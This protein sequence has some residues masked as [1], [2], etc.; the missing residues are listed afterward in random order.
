MLLSAL[1]SIQRDVAEVI[2]LP[3]PE[4]YVTIRVDTH[5]KTLRVEDVMGPWDVSAKLRKVFGFLQKH[6][7]VGNGSYFAGSAAAFLFFIIT[8]AANIWVT[9]NGIKGGIE[10]LCNWAMPTLFVLGVILAIRV[11]TLDAPPGAP[12]DQNAINGLGFLW[13]PDFSTLSDPKVWVAAAG[14]IF[15][16]LSLGMGVIISYASYL[17]RSDDVA[18]SGLTASATTRGCEQ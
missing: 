7:G 8:F 9:R 17:K 11:L 15:F 6:Q 1:N 5:E 12:V 3:G 18:L 14:Q 2:I 10:K 16:T 4:G 13:N